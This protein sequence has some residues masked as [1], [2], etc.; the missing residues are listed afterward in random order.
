MIDIN[1]YIDGDKF[2]SIAD[3]SFGDFF[4]EMRQLNYESLVNFFNGFSEDR[5]PVIY[6][7]SGRVFDLFDILNQNKFD[8]QFI[9]LSHNDDETF[10]LSSLGD[11]SYVLGKNNGKKSMVPISMVKW[12]G[13]NINFKNNE[14][15]IS[16]P[17]GLER[18]FWSK[19]RYGIMGLKHQ[20]IF[21]Y[22]QKKLIK[23][24]ICYLNFDIGTNSD[25]RNW[26]GPFFKDYGWCNVNLI[27]LNGN[28]DTYFSE[29]LESHSVLCPVGNGIDCHR[30]WEMLYL[31]VLPIVE[32]SEFSSEIY[33][34]LPVLIIDDFRNLTE[35]I[36][37][38][39][40]N[41]NNINYNFQK[42]S[43]T[44]WEKLIKNSC[45]L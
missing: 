16:L 32:Y 19:S 41:E 14:K 37:L 2:E 22:S 44:Y 39:K 11:E 35:K 6:I 23:K 15:I 7:N 28:L 40:I 3:L 8:K 26:I 38:D 36:I 31:G 17:I 24:N 13:Q 45:K 10:N 29:C 21:E 20:K 4:T 34:D 1:D 30:N 43:F 5:I 12:F 18:K 33:G 27:G 42:L 9:L 25:K